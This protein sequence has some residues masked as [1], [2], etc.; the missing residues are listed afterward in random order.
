M[1]TKEAFWAWYNVHIAARWWASSAMWVGVI[2]STLPFILDGA[3]SLLD[4][5][6]LLAGALEWSPGTVMRVQLGLAVL[7]PPLRAW[8]Q[9]SIESATLAQAASTGKV[10]VN[11]AS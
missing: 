11:K 6:N 3:Q 9:A 8:R 10:I 2:A 1:F 5:I 7:I 4:N